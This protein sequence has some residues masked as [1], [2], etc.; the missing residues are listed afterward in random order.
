M[1]LAILNF[2]LRKENKEKIKDK[3]NR[4][5]YNK[6]TYQNFTLYK[7]KSIIKLF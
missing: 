3:I 5:K 4:K 2:F 1:Y 6:K 7:I